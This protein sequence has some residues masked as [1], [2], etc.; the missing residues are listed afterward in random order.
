MDAAR[1]P[2]EYVR[3]ITHN[4]WITGAE[5]STFA[6]YDDRLPPHLQLFIFDSHK[7]DFDIS[8]YEAAALEFLDEVDKEVARLR[9]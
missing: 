2:P 7:N 5:F 9:G 3:Q 8:G 1:V 6:S 4:L